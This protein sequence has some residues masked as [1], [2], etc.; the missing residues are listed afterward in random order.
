MKFRVRLVEGETELQ[1]ISVTG[2]IPPPG[3]LVMHGER[4]WFASAPAWV[5]EGK[6]LFPVISLTLH[7]PKKVPKRRGPTRSQFLD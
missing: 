2:E 3:T 4:Q 1:S 5:L 7:S 6:E